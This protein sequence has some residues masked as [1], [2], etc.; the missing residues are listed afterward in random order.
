MDFTQGYILSLIR[1]SKLL[2]LLK[3]RDICNDDRNTKFAN[4]IIA[5]NTLNISITGSLNIYF[6]ATYSLEQ[7]KGSQFSNVSLIL[8]IILVFFIYYGGVFMQPFIYAYIIQV[9]TTQINNLNTSFK[10]GIELEIHSC[11][12][13]I[14]FLYSHSDGMKSGA[15]SQ[16]RCKLWKINVKLRELESLLSPF[17]LLS[18]MTNTMIIM[19]GICFFAT[20]TKFFDSFIMTF[21]FA[22]NLCFAILKNFLYFNFGEQIPKSFSQLK[23]I[24]EE[25]SLKTNFSND[26][27]KELIAIKAMEK[28][29]NFTLYNILK[30]KRKT[31]I[32]VCS[33]ILQYAVILIQTNS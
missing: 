16:L 19:A 14:F 21:F 15:L 30:L 9:I 29:F 13:N 23:N 10:T 17:L 3:T 20:A 1:G 11:F 22:V 6:F 28:D 4:K 26:D 31:A 32:T 33:F 2:N 25:L 27:Y 5:F 12:A 7:I 24:L 18:L 8:L